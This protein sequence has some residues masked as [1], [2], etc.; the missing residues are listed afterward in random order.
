MRHIMDEVSSVVHESV[1]NRT[2]VGDGDE[3]DGDGHSRS[4]AR[5]NLRQ[6]IHTVIQLQKTMNRLQ[7]I[8]HP[9]FGSKP[10]TS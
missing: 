7:D 1:S 6:S 5:R 10:N 8:D 3:E 9:L 2:E 4:P